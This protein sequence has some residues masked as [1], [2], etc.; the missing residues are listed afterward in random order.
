MAKT[1][2]KA[3]ALASENK[4]VIYARFSCEKQRQESIEDQIRVCTEYAAKNNLI[5]VASYFD[6]AITGR[7]DDRPQ[8]QR[9]IQDS[10]LGGW[11]KVIIYKIDRFARNR[12]DSAIY[13]KQL[14]NYGV[15]V[16]SATEFI[17]DSPGGILME[18]LY[19]GWAELYSVQLSENVRRAAKGKALKCQSNGGRQLFGYKTNKETGQ[20]EL[21]EITAP[22][23]KEIFTRAA[24]GVSP[25]EIIEWLGGLGYKYTHNKLYYMLRN[26]RYKGIY[27]Y[28]GQRIEGGQPAIIDV[29]TFDRAQRFCKVRGHYHG[30]DKNAY[31]FAGKA[32]CGLCGASISGE[33]STG[34]GGVYKYYVCVKHKR[35]HT[36]ALPR[37]RV[38]HLEDRALRA[39]M[40]ALSQPAARQLLFNAAAD[41]IKKAA[42]ATDKTAPLVLRLKD[43]Q[44]RKNNIV[45]AFELNADIASLADRLRELEKEETALKLAIAREKIID[46]DIELKKAKFFIDRFLDGKVYDRQLA[47]DLFQ[48]FINQVFVY[49]EHIVL[50]YDVL[51]SSASTMS[52]TDVAEI[53]QHQGYV[54]DV[55]DNKKATHDDGCV[56]GNTWWPQQ[57]SNLRPFDS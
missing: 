26:E 22:I 3:G 23:A 17:P 15:K 54:V 48:A 33:T 7:T 27:I 2:K 6:M 44:K 55:P 18:S 43:V 34:H 56:A 12:Y 28:D 20:Y 39:V 40:A 47:V 25:S 45:R 5:I 24:A 32:V 4:A 41:A 52:I 38:E 11:S 50:V 13:K 46:P 8:F 37:R 10:A 9:M 42:A 31:L 14:A 29:D 36:C 21:D 30:K 1:N 49:P 57:D 35:Q 53:T 19:E 51:Q 16:V